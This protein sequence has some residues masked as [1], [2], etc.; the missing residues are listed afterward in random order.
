MAEL[1]VGKCIGV[2]L[3]MDEIGVVEVD[4]KTVRCSNCNHL[5]TIPNSEVTLGPPREVGGLPV[6]VSVEHRPPVIGSS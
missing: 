3:Q 2:I 1:R 4:G 6:I 5:T